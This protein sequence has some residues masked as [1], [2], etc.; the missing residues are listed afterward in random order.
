MP[1]TRQAIA[2]SMEA[3]AVR[4]ADGPPFEVVFTDTRSG[5]ADGLFFALSGPNHDAH[6]YLDAALDAG[7]R[8]L[9][10]TRE[11]ALPGGLPGD[12]FVAVVPDTRVALGQLGGLVRQHL[13][14][15]VIAVTGSVGK[16]TVK[17]MAVAALGAFGSATG[18]PGNYNNDIGLPL[19]LCA[20]DGTESYVV[21]ELGMSAA[22]EIADL[23]QIAQPQVG[24]VTGAEAAHLAFFDGVD[25]IADAKAELYERMPEGSRA[26]ACA[27]DPRVVARARAFRPSGLITYGLAR[28]ADVRV[29]GVEQSL[30]GLQVQIVGADSEPVT[31]RL[32]CLGLHNGVN[33]AGALAIVQALGLPLGPAAQSLGARF[34]PAAHRLN[35]VRGQDGLHILDDSYNANPASARAALDTLATIGAGAPALGAVLGSML[36]LGPSAQALHEELGRQAAD[37]GVSWLGATGPHADA[38]AGSARRAGLEDVRTAADAMELVDDLRAFSEPGRW[39]LLKGSRGERLERLLVPLGLEGVS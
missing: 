27:D 1:M 24:L 19:S 3:T 6:D 12:V 20:L 36:E 21:L 37:A 34:R 16:T 18:S 17:D 5:G 29:T 28:E 22:G 14:G 15:Q 32:D 9:V 33:A 26:V 25:A 13:Q 31:V 23:T 7:A 11:D 38:V 39:L 10:V 8:G 4:G 2:Q 35:V 30:A